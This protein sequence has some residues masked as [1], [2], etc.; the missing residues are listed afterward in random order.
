MACNLPRM[1]MKF[2]CWADLSIAAY[3]CNRAHQRPRLIDN[4]KSK[5]AALPIVKSLGLTEEICGR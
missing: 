5:A 3:Q 4:G 2:T 1:E